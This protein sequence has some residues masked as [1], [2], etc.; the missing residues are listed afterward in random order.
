M[1]QQ[2]SKLVLLLPALLIFSTLF[3]MEESRE[4]RDRISL[5]TLSSSEAVQKAE[6]KIASLFSNYYKSKGKICSLFEQLIDV[7]L[8]LDSNGHLNKSVRNDLIELIKD[9]SPKFSSCNLSQ[10]KLDELL[11]DYVHNNRPSES[12]ARLILL[13]AN[14]NLIF[15]CRDYGIECELPLINLL[16]RYDVFSDLVPILLIYGANPNLVDTLGHSALLSAAK[17]VSEKR[18]KKINQLI[19]FGADVNSEDQMKLSSVSHILSCLDE[20]TLQRFMR[21]GYR[22]EA[23]TSNGELLLRHVRDSEPKILELLIKYGLDINARSSSGWTGLIHAVHIQGI[24]IIDVLL[25]HGAKDLPNYEET[26]YDYASRYSKLLGAPKMLEIVK[27]FEHYRGKKYTAAELDEDM[28][29]L[30]ISETSGENDAG[31]KEMEIDN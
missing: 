15:P 25:K 13:G 17:T 12:I 14:P 24:E 20:E 21:Y 31:E 18:L 5:S 27:L 9:R 28:Q 4:K 22:L 3:G 6:K 1:K 26:A 29:D 8:E 10:E 11:R 23:V 7:L 16:L 2:I 19:I 30:T